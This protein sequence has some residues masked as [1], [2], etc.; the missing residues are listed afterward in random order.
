MFLNLEFPFKSKLSPCKTNCQN[1]KPTQR[2]LLLFFLQGKMTDCD[3][4]VV[5]LI[6]EKSKEIL[7]KDQAIMPNTG[8]MPLGNDIYVLK[9]SS[10]LTA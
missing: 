4:K 6:V 9:P 8:S 10:D 3:S 5:G 1:P 7:K 2:D